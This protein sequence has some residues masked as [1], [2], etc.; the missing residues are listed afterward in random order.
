M[1]ATGPSPQALAKAAWASVHDA[2]LPAWRTSRN[3]QGCQFNW[4][5]AK[6]RGHRAPL[7]TGCVLTPATPTAQFAAMRTRRPQPPSHNVQT[8]YFVTTG[9]CAGCGI[10]GKF[11]VQMETSL[12]SFHGTGVST[13]PAMAPAPPINKSRLLSFIVAPSLMTTEAAHLDVAAAVAVFAVAHRHAIVRSA[14]EA[15]DR[16]A[17]Y[18]PAV[19]ADAVLLVDSRLVRLPEVSVAVP[20]GQTGAARVDRMREPDV[21]R[22]P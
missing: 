12:K 6:A 15:G 5:A 7:E 9:P 10:Q 13:S 19:A 14:P 22:L 4:C 20:A 11:C 3:R 2:A 21:G 18:I 8:E 17:R 1:M 16:M